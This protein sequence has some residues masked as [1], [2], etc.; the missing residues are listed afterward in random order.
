[1]GQQQGKIR[2]TCQNCAHQDGCLRKGLLV[3]FLFI[4]TGREKELPGRLADLDIR[5]HCGSWQPK[6]EKE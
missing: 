3:F 5:A 2:E 4:A 6:C 1:M